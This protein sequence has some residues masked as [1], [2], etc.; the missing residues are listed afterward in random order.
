MCAKLYIRDFISHLFPHMAGEI[1][2]CRDLKEV[3][4]LVERI[5]FEEIVGSLTLSKLNQEIEDLENS[6]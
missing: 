5:K 6:L 4:K 2:K 3:R 1:E